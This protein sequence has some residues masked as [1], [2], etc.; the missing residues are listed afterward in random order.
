MRNER[1]NPLLRCPNQHF[2]TTTISNP[3]ICPKGFMVISHSQVLNAVLD[4]SDVVML[5][6]E[7]ANGKFPEQADAFLSYSFWC[8]LVVLVLCFRFGSI[9]S[10]FCL[11][12]GL[13][14]SKKR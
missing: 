7:T 13:L 1:V 8:G 11:H 3:P 6:G 4:G 2:D 14:V 10:S 5:S 9:W 12:F